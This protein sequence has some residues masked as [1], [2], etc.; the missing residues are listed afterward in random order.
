[1]PKIKSAVIVPQEVWNRLALRVGD[2][3]AAYARSDAGFRCVDKETGKDLDDDGRLHNYLVGVIAGFV[4]PKAV[5]AA[6]R[7]D[8]GSDA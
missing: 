4:W 3:L 7:H 1:M 6:E 8:G 5:K 2:G